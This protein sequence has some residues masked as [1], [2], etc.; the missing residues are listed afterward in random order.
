MRRIEWQECIKSLRLVL[1]APDAEKGYEDLKKYFNY[2]KMHEE[3]DAIDFL[4]KERFRDHRS[5][6]DKK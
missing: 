3:S 2:N 6:I 4:I 5:N 1:E